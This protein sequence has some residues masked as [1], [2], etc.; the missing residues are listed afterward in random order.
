MQTQTDIQKTVWHFASSGG[1]TQQKISA[2][3]TAALEKQA[4]TRCTVTIPGQ[5]R[6]VEFLAV[7]HDIFVNSGVNWTVLHERSTAVDPF[8]A[9]TLVEPVST[10]MVKVHNHGGRQQPVEKTRLDTYPDP[11]KHR[12]NCKQLPWLYC[13]VVYTAPCG[14]TWETESKFT[15]PETGM[16]TVDVETRTVTCYSE[17]LGASHTWQTLLNRNS[18]QRHLK[19][20]TIPQG[21]HRWWEAYLPQAP[22]L[23]SKGLASL[24]KQKAKQPFWDALKASNLAWRFFCYL[25]EGKTRDKTSNNKLIK[26]SCEAHGWTQD[27]GKAFVA[28]LLEMMKAPPSFGYHY[29]SYSDS[30]PNSVD[31]D[32]TRELC[33]ALGGAADAVQEAEAK[34]DHR[35]AKTAAA[36]AETLGITVRQYPKL[37]T[38]ITSGDWPTSVFTNPDGQAVN[39]EFPLIEQGLSQKG[40]AETLCEIATSAGWRGTYE[41]DL[42]PYINFLLHS[43]PAY[44]QRCTGGRKKW[45]CMPKFVESQWELEMDEDAKEG[46]SKKRSAFTPTADNETRVVTVP[47]VAVCVSGVRTQW[48]YSRFYHVFEKGMT[49]PIS[50]GIVLNDYE[51]RLNGRDDYGLMYYTL[52]GTITA[53]GYPT[54]LIIFERQYQGF[55]QAHDAS[56][57][58]HVHFHRC[59]PKRLDNGKYR[60]ACQLVEAT[61]QYMAGNIPAGD[62]EAQQG[63]MIYI[64]HPNDPIAAGA[65]VDSPHSGPVLN[66]ESHNHVPNVEGEQLSL[67]MSKAKTPKNRLGFIKVPPGGMKINHPEHDDVENINEGWFEV[68]RCRSFEANPKAIWSYTVD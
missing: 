25:T 45:T 28:E 49:D 66:F 15:M 35:K 57:K 5:D 22:D 17:F 19:G 41:K 18:L 16:A 68:R 12:H 8:I 40:W 54:F 7:G 3:A 33:M 65:K 34:I 61:Y 55:D 39:R 63:D 56:Y 38:A 32:D 23:D 50:G 52:T 62:I 51:A 60:P 13:K 9:T 42:T 30:R 2:T 48:C 6:S 21:A 4:G 46:T 24:L 64:K 26:A 10:R 31:C 37:H 53:R 67:Y 59:H 20:S 44:L 43:L 27:G 47:Y 11:N 36:A 1:H 14:A 58:T 29:D